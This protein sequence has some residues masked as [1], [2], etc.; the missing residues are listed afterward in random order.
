MEII[1]QENKLPRKTI[2]RIFK[3]LNIHSISITFIALAAIL[4]S[5]K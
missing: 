4:T 1:S 3:I 5:V 2:E